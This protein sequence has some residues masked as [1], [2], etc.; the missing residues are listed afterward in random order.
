MKNKEDFEKDLST[1]I[2]VL[3]KLE[4]KQ[5][6]AI[7]EFSIEK[8]KENFS[9]FDDQEYNLLKSLKSISSKILFI[10]E[11]GY[12]KEKQRFF[13]FDKN[14]VISDIEFIIKEHFP[15][16]KLKEIN[17]S[18]NTKT[19]NRQNILNIFSYKEWKPFKEDFIKKAKDIVSI[20][21]FPQYIFKEILRFS[22]N[23]RIILPPYREI[24]IIISQTILWEEK[25]LFSLL[26][27]L[28]DNELKELVK[29]L[30]NKNEDETNYLLSTIRPPITGFCYS[31]VFTETDKQ[32][33][34]KPIFDKAKKILPQ[35]KISNLTIKYFSKL[36]DKYN[37]N[38]FKR[39]NENKQL[40]IVLC[41]VYYRYM[42][43]NDNLVKTFLYLMDKYEYEIK[44]LADKE[45]I[46]I[47]SDNIE[48]IKKIP[49]I[50][51]LFYENKI[52]EQISFKEIKNIVFSIIEE[53][54]IK[55]L[56]E[57]LIK[58]SFDKKSYEWIEYDKKYPTIK[59]NIRYIFQ[60]LDFTHDKLNNNNN[61]INLFESIPFLKKVLNDKTKNFDLAPCDFINPKDFKYLFE[62]KIDK[63]GK[64]Y[65]ELI[66]KRY[67]LLLYLSIKNRLM[68]GDIF[69]NDSIEN[70]SLEDDL[71]T[72]EYFENNY[73]QISE[74]LNLPLFSLDFEELLDKKLELLE[75]LIEK[76][77][78]NILADKNKYFKII[79]INKK[80]WSLSY[81]GIQ[82]EEVNNPIFVKLP[83]T[84]LI[85][86][87]RFVNKKTDF[88]SSFT[89]ILN[90]NAKK[91]LDENTAIAT[92]IAYGTNIGLSKMSISS[93][94]NYNHIKNSSLNYFREDTLKIANE[95]IVNEFSNLPIF[96]YYN[97]IDE[98]IHSSSDGQR[99]NVSGNV[100][101]A[102]HSI[103]NPGREK[104]LTVLTLKANYTPLNSKV[105]SGNE[106]EG[107]HVLEL[108]LMNESNVQ[109]KIHSTDNHGTNKIN[110]VLLD[111]SD[112]YFSPRY[113]DLNSKFKFL[114]G[115]KSIKDYSSKYILKPIKKINKELIISEEKNIKRVMASI[116]LK[117]SSVSTIVKK[118]NS[119]QKSNKT[120]KA[121][122][123]YDKI[124]RS[125]HILNYIDNIKLRQ[126]TQTSLNRVEA[127]HQL[128]RAI[129]YANFGRIRA[130]IHSEQIIY[131]ECT[132]LISTAIIFYNS[133][134]LSEFL[135]QKKELGEIEQV[136]AIKRVS[137]IAWTHINLYG[138]F[139]FSKEE[140]FFENF[141]IQEML[142]RQYLFDDL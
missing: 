66:P 131:Q 133:Y 44:T 42:N 127:Y 111:F 71:I 122:A 108:L 3:N 99:F 114:Y 26:D 79:D 110:H 30:L 63:N 88:L 56:S 75:M 52:S 34:I 22:I 32:K 115:S 28:I 38:N 87:I 31:D 112:Y 70:R 117:N 45:I 86:L 137:P 118:L 134:I 50:L 80:T 43:I 141:N 106:Y 78:K 21:S 121:F 83:Q 47:N 113:K 64:K 138:K 100:F 5:Y 129:F 37:I 4:Q 53:D 15:K 96:E 13:I 49:Q 97:I 9:L 69:F 48:N 17:F 126:S 12:F 24:Q 93:G 16:T 39:F 14:N 85:D 35:L 92:I 41:F 20:D 101:N 27:N 128:K 116:L 104:G 82:D 105:I 68:A 90:K 119:Y 57:Y 6:Y 54:K 94:I 72:K 136:E 84:E 7:P 91:E 67:E 11:L 36:L 77:N 62:N 25:R 102:R 98:I 142:K 124:C 95:K 132:R 89:H 1:K 58:E 125:I 33:K 65:R 130:K 81:D 2:K 46:T 140:K 59:R 23:N 123:E 55:L 61:L 76:V 19:S 8:R 109:P 139:D 74:I 29:S 10:L 60:I 135:K 103:K 73:E 107:H 40:F 120:M 51:S 18:K